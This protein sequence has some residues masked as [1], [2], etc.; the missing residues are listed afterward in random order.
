MFAAIRLQG[1]GFKPR[2]G[3]KF[4]TK[5]LLHSNP[6]GG[7]GMSP[8]QGEAIRRHYIKPEYLFYPT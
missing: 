1:P 6:Y 8:V 7:E 5:F 4:E 2:P 3:H